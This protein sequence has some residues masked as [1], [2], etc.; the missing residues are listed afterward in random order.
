V[1]YI[2]DRRLVAPAS[3]ITLAGQSALNLESVV[4]SGSV[5]AGKATSSCM[6]AWCSPEN[7]RARE[8]FEAAGFDWTRGGPTH[9][10]SH[11]YRQYLTLDAKNGEEAI[12]RSRS[13]I[14]EARGDS[15]DLTV[16][17]PDPDRLRL[18]DG[19]FLQAQTEAR[20]S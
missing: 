7:D 19:A 1:A 16:V 9:P 13:I 10:Y 14:D 2:A 3:K 12:A 11:R 6:I 4:S 17:Q 8:L 5:I 20:G 15:T 18:I